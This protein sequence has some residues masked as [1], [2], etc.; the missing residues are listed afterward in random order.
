MSEFAIGAIAV[1]ANLNPTISIAGTLPS[2]GYHL[3]I[4]WKYVIALTACIAGVH[5]LLVVLILWIARPIIIGGE[6]TLATARLLGG[7]V[8]RLGG[9]GCL[10]DGRDIAEMIQEKETGEKIGAASGG[11]VYGVRKTEEGRMVVELG[12]EIEVRKR[13]NGGRFPRGTYM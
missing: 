4:K 8:G 5:T 9:E 10:L 3:S 1:M 11:V 12:G 2:L 7:L 13:L 6:S